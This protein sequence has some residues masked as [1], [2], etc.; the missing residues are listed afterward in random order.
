MRNKKNDNFL[1]TVGICTAGL[2]GTIFLPTITTVALGVAAA[3]KYTDQGKKHNFLTLVGAFAGAAFAGPS[4]LGVAALGA[5]GYCYHRLS[6]GKSFSI[7][8][9]SEQAIVEQVKN[10]L[11]MKR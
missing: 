11:K 1:K 9:K 6:E 2:I 7:G 10:T 8:G 3:Y 5:F 4:V